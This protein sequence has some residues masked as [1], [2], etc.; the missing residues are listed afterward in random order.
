MAVD[1][2]GDLE[3]V[4]KLV[5]NKREPFGHNCRRG[6]KSDVFTYAC[7][8]LLSRKAAESPRRH[9][10][11]SE[12]AVQPH[13]VVHKSEKEFQQPVVIL[14]QENLVPLRFQTAQL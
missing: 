9:L 6:I 3:V 7:K 2:H 13:A 4:G 5:V 12:V 10:H 1:S 11:N 14:W 8:R